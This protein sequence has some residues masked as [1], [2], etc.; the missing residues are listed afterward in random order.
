MRADSPEKDEQHDKDRY[1]L[2]Y[3]DLITLLLGLFILL[4]ATSSIDNEKYQEMQSAFG[5]LF[6]VQ[7]KL[8]ELPKEGFIITKE[9]VFPINRTKNILQSLI[10]SSNLSQ[11]INLTYNDR[12]I[13][14][15]ILEDIIF[16]SGEAELKTESQRLLK[17]LAKIIKELPNEVRIE[18]H[19]D[20]L[21]INSTRYPSN[22]HLSVERAT[23]TA[24]YLMEN[25]GIDP[26]KVS[27]VGFSSYKPLASNS[28]PEGRA[29]NRR[30]DIVILKQ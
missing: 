3:A 29:M 19:T 18:G 11:S 16:S 20:N 14:I 24:Y 12:G 2:T 4:Y 28:T 27:I 21:P 8:K 30:V 17:D 23:N 25:E 26:A 15:S 7:N 9:N 13:T 5:N 10:D 6:G 1:L 22:W